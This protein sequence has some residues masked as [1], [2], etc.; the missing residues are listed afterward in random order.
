[1]RIP[2][3]LSAP[4]CGV[5]LVVLLLVVAVALGVALV[6]VAVVGVV[7]S[8]D[9]EWAVASTIGYTHALPAT[10]VVVYDHGVGVGY[11]V[12]DNTDAA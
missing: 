1:M 10:A 6:V 2:A 8:A 3:A 9:S 4:F 11:D 12:V 7:E 5:G